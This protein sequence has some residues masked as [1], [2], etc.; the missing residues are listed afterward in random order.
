MKVVFCNPPS[1]ETC[2]ISRGLMGGF[3]MAVGEGLVYPPLNVAYCAAVLLRKGHGAE[4][5]DASALGL[6]E[7]QSIQR[8]ADSLPDLIVVNTSSATIALD[9]RVGSAAGSAAGVPVVALGSQVTH[10]PDYILSQSRVDYVVRGEPE[11]T[12]LDLVTALEQG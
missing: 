11:Y 9:M 7:A 8:M 6:D 12:L 3:G 5:I 4:V 1:P 10:A 2:K